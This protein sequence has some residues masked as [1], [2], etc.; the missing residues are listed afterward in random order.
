M[1][2]RRFRFH[3]IWQSKAARIPLFQWCDIQ[4]CDITVRN[5][6]RHS[7]DLSPACGRGRRCTSPAAWCSPIFVQEFPQASRRSYPRHR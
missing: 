5:R 6:W 7:R 4:W 1:R 2:A 3:G